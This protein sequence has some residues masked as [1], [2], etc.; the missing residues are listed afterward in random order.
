MSI[1]VRLTG[2]KELDA[3][4]TG[5]SDRVRLA[6]YKKVSALTAKLYAKVIRK[7]SGEVLHVRSNTLRGSIFIIDPN[8]YDNP[9]VG[10]V[11]SAG[12]AKI[13]GVDY[14]NIWENTGHK[15]I[16]PTK[17][18]ALRFIVG[19]EVVFAKCVSAQAPRPFI[20]P[21]LAE[22]EPEFGPALEEAV[23]E[24]LAGKT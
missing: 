22:I 24:G 12:T 16:I 23:A 2:E 4:I 17:A 9:I 7:L 5:A 8:P 18:K 10:K 11:G 19:G 1:E 21:S 6:V 13:G 14:A 20:K 15:E 3:V